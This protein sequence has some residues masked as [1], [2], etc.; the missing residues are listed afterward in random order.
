MDGLS[1]LLQLHVV[2]DDKVNDKALATRNIP[3]P[4][5]YLLRPDGYIGLSGATIDAGAVRQYLAETMR[6]RA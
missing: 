2:P 5:F 1:D 3:K 6:V 4:S